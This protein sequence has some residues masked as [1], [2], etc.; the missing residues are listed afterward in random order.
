MS[1]IREEALELHKR[2][3]GK[4]E[5]NSRTTVSDSYSLSLAYTPGVESLVWL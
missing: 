1:N 4:I 5:V 2:L 3:K